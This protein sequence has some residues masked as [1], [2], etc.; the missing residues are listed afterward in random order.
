MSSLT[1]SKAMRFGRSLSTRRIINQLFYVE[2][3][4]GIVK[5]SQWGAKLTGS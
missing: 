1:L 5:I 4:I 3:A 2:L